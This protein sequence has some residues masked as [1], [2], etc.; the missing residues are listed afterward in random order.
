[1]PEILPDDVYI[2][3]GEM[4]FTNDGVGFIF[5]YVEDWEEYFLEY[6]YIVEEFDA[7]DEFERYR[8]TAD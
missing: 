3:D 1:M 6:P 5:F 2:V 4:A 7:Y 8:E